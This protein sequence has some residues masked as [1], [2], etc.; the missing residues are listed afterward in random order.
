[1]K[2]QIHLAA[3][4]LLSTVLSQSPALSQGSLT[5][6]GAPAPTMK[7]LQQ[8]EPRTP[9][10]AAP[11]TI[12]E[13]GS[14]YLTTNLTVSSGDAITIAASGVTLDL[15]GYTIRSTTNSPGGAAIAIVSGLFGLRNLAILNGN[16]EGGGF[17]YGIVFS[18]APPQNVRVSG[19]NVAGCLYDG[20]SLGWND[21]TVVE[22][23][24]VRTVGG[25]GIAA[26]TIKGSS[27]I[28][29]G[30]TAIAGNQVSDCR[31][32]SASGDGVSADVALNC[33]GESGN[34]R[35]V[36][37]ARSAQNCYGS[38]S[39]SYGVYAVS[40]QNCYGI[41][42]GTGVSATTA[43]N[44]YGYNGTSASGVS[45]DIAQN[46]YGSSSGGNGVYAVAIAQNCYGSS[47]GAGG[48]GVVV[49][50][51]AQNCYGYSSSGTGVAADTAQ[52]CYGFSGV[53]G[54]GIY[55]SRTAIG[56]FG[57]SS[58][59]PAGLFAQNA[60]TCTGFRPSGRAIWATIGNGCWAVGGTNFI[61]YKY[62]MP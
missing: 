54:Y 41:S 13:P 57:D 15:N 36:Y 17:G 10:S 27:A 26:S 46:C 50:Y 12:T 62:N 25:Y 11:F 34:G 29:C 8:V 56:C 58:S 44:C 43:L 37:A 2:T 47:G 42:G 55:A 24:T 48:G 21:S 14:Y 28:N 40:A 20:I 33:Y 22:A 49:S 51:T 38:S 9:I 18:N 16:I 39:S 52:N 6:P 4:A 19:I 23:C 32:T 53:S 61:T 3:L 59:G 7:T 31:G 30:L 60:N 5:P 35:G 1:M 45:A